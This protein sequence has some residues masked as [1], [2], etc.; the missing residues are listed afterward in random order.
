MLDISD[1]AGRGWLGQQREH[2]SK[3]GD[4]IG[5]DCHSDKGVSNCCCQLENPTP[6]PGGVGHYIL[7][8]S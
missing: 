8:E 5:D 7:E 1:G 4:K 3:R 6:V 2:H